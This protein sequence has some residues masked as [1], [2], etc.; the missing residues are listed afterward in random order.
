MEVSA[1]YQILEAEIRPDGTRIITK[2][3][4]VSAGATAPE[5]HPT[6]LATGSESVGMAGAGPVRSLEGAD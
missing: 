3:R 2:A 1:V 6:S 4:L 5:A